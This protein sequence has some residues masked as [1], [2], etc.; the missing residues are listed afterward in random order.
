M[1]RR[2]YGIVCLVAAMV[3]VTTLA[4]AEPGLYQKALSGSAN[5]TD[6]PSDGGVVVPGALLAS[7]AGSST[8][9]NG[10]T[11]SMG[12]NQTFAYKGVMFMKGGVTYWFVKNYDDNGYIGIADLEGTKTVIINDTGW[13]N[14]KYGSFTPADDGFYGIDLR[15]GNGT[16]GKGPAAAPFNS[17]SQLGAGLAWNTNGLESCTSSNWSQWRKFMNTDDDVFLYT[18]VPVFSRLKITLGAN[19]VEYDPLSSANVPPVSVTD[20]DTGSLLSEGTDYEIAFSNATAVGTA[21]VYVTGFGTYDG[22]KAK[23]NYKIVSDRFLPPGYRQLK[24]IRSTGTQYI[25]T[26]T[27]PTS[28]TTVEFDFNSGTT[29]NDTTFFG[30]Y[31]GTGNYL[32]IRQSDK[33]KFFGAGTVIGDWHANTDIHLSVTSNNTTVLDWGDGTATTTSVSRTSSNNAFN[34]FADNTG[35]RKGSWTFYSMKIWTDGQMARDFVPARRESDGAIGLYDRTSGVFYANAGTGVFIAG[36]SVDSVFD[37]AEIAP[38][39]SVAGVPACP[40]PEVRLYTTGELLSEGTDYEVVYSNNTGRGTAT[41]TVCGLGIY[42]AWTNSVTFEVYLPVAAGMKLLEYVEFTGQQYVNTGIFYND[43]QIEV[44]FQTVTYV[45]DGY[46]FGLGIGNANK[47]PQLTEY[48]NAYYWGYDGGAEGNTSGKL[49]TNLLRHQM[50]YNRAG[51]RAVVFDGTVYA[52]GREPGGAGQN[53]FVACRGDSISYK[54]RIYRFAAVNRAT[55]KTELELVPAKNAEGIA[56]FFDLVSGSFLPPLP[57]SASAVTP[58]TAGPEVAIS[59]F[60]VSAVPV[61]HNWADRSGSPSAGATPSL[62]VSNLVAGTLL[63]EGQDYSVSY[64][65]NVS[66]GIAKAV[67][68]GLGT[69]T[70]Q[71]D[72]VC[73]RVYNSIFEEYRPLEY[74]EATNN[75]VWVG[76]DYIHTTSTR[77]EVV[78]CVPK[79]TLG[80][81]GSRYQAILGGRRNSA[82]QESF[83]F[84]ARFNG[85][86]RPVWSRNAETQG[87]DNSYPYDEWVS[88]DCG[89]DNGLVASW[90]GLETGLTG[91][92]TSS[93][94]VNGSVPLAIFANNVYNGYRLRYS[95]SD[96]IA[97]KLKSFKI[98]ENGELV[99]DYIPCRRLSDGKIGLYERK[100]NRFFVNRGAGEL[101]AGRDVSKL[102]IAYEIPDQ[103][104]V[105][106][107]AVT[108][109]VTV[110]DY[111]TGETLTEGV[112]YT[113]SYTNN[114]APG[115][116]RVVLTGIGVY[117]GETGGRDFKIFDGGPA[118]PYPVFSRSYVPEGLIGFWDGIDNTGTGVHDANAATWADLSG[119][120]Y[121]GTMNGIAAWANGNAMHNEADGHPCVLPAAFSSNWNWHDV[122]VEFA[123]R[124]SE[125]DATRAIFSNYSGASPW[126]T[127][128][129]HN[130]GTTYSD[131]SVRL[132]NRD[133]G[134]TG[135]TKIASVVK[136][137]ELAYFTVLSEFNYMFA[138]RDSATGTPVT[139]S[140]VYG[141]KV[142]TS[143]F[144]IGGRP[145]AATHAMRGDIHFVRVYNRNLDE[146]E[147][148]FNR[149]LDVIR[150]EN[151]SLKYVLPE[152]LPDGY[153]YD[154]ARDV[155]RVRI[156]AN[157]LHTKGL[158][159]INGAAAGK[160]PEAWVDVGTAV[161][162]E[163]SGDGFLGWTNLP[164][165][166]TYPGTPASGRVTFTAAAPVR[167]VAL[168][169][170]RSAAES[171]LTPYSYVQKGIVRLWD[172]IDNTGSGVHENTNR[173][174]DLAGSGAQWILRANYGSFAA[175]ALSIAGSNK[176]SAHSKDPVPG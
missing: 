26:G 29:A 157:A 75:N 158:V 59:D 134:G 149:A 9:Y 83:V 73:F 91:S 22:E 54:G 133:T 62:V 145:D 126:G 92:L 99:H 79:A 39:A 6:D 5:I 96:Y 58:L 89:G 141:R 66:N 150:Y 31:W 77:V 74:V 154:A 60:S 33:F 34:I 102:H 115:T 110:T 135:D 146:K 56:G 63:T 165:A 117:A 118:T 45:N 120:G 61:Q 23:A 30:Q 130:N 136:A 119:L 36:P 143:A 90:E 160:M 161:T 35:N 127:I 38:A 108:P 85:S 170:A 109:A 70:G 17:A 137:G 103:A 106:Y 57:N 125:L 144:E 24:F 139:S 78:S 156:C 76:S 152:E 80:I 129:S 8:S 93:K 55:G 16:S 25:K 67:I 13:D 48:S 168:S 140:S 32:F 107:A 153:G 173:W 142:S 64:L 132:Y 84:F 163:Y 42:A 155:L 164:S 37:I 114:T 50:V 98:Y 100:W 10:T 52:Y 105:G 147:R 28:T 11:Y 18:E 20:S 44:D 81:N 122:T 166:Y 68:D 128:I 123:F 151:R 148:A 116:G 65:N 82:S 176:E 53:L 46:I 174:I 175:K 171:D 51:D 167:A 69:Y 121:H 111:T 4:D 1:K 138:Y 12:D 15:V 43:H 3:A 87:T 86:N 19:S 95:I 112:D 124:P 27:L 14:V 162:L 72:I 7:I 172:G 2:V 40:S 21:T 49:G 41:A 131:G 113:V 159:S 104:Q 94:N 97:M 88:L 71:R 47:Y 169:S 101:L